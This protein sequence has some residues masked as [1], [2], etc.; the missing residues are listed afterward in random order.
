MNLGEAIIA[1]LLL[2]LI[3]VGTM[4]SIHGVGVGIISTGTDLGVLEVM[5]GEI[6]G[7]GI[8]TVFGTHTILLSGM[9]GT[10]VSLVAMVV[11][12]EAGLSII[13]AGVKIGS[14]DLDSIMDLEDT[15][16]QQTL[17][18]IEV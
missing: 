7:V 2:T 9:V 12:M 10:M 3:V 14:T 16:D 5:A 8:T 1:M 4:A 15:L 6:D 13:G 18:E 11:S 17:I